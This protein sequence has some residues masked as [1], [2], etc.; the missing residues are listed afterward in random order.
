[1][2]FNCG[3]NYLGKYTLIITE[4]PDAAKRIA[5]ALD[6]NG[7]ANKNVEHG[8]PFYQ[9]YR[10]GEI[11]VVPA[12]G[13]MYTVASKIKNS[14]DYPVFDCTW[15]PRYL[16]EHKSSKIRVWLG[17]I[18]KLAKNAEVFVD[19][20]DFDIEG[21]I[22]GYCLLKYACG[23]KEKAAKRM[24]YSTL[25]TEDLQQS[26]V[27]ILPSLD[28]ALV[29]AGLAR[30]EIDWLY[31]INLSRA[32]TAAA[33]SSS[34]QY[35]T[36]ST[37]RVQ[38]PTLKFL[39]DREKSINSFVPTPYWTIKAKIWINDIAYEFDYEKTLY[40][41]QEANA[42]METCKTKEGQIKKITVGKFAQK[43]PFPFDL[44]S[45]QS[46]AYRLFHYSPMRTLNIA[47]RLYTNALISYPRT[48]S[49]KLP[50][51]IGY[52]QILK[53][54]SQLPI[55]FKVASQLLSKSMLKPHEGIKSDS[56][57]PAI[58]PTGNL[59]EE[60]LGIPERN[61]FDLVVG[62][63]MAVFGEPATRQSTEL[64]LD[65]NG[66]NF[67]FSAIQTL[68]NGW[69]EFYKPYVD[70]KD[71][72]CPST[73]EGQKVEVKRVTLKENFTKA[74]PRYNPSSLLLKM[75]KEEIGTKATRAAIIQTL[76]DRKY[77]NGAGSLAVSQLGLEVI[78]VLEKYCPS[79]ISLE[80]T[81]Q[82][83][84][85]MNQI[86]EGS[87]TKEVVL[88]KAIEIL[89]PVLS[90]L[91]I[92]QSVVGFK[93]SEA[94]NQT[95]MEQRTI[96][97]CPKCS[98][99]KLV[100]VRSKK[101]QKRFVGCANYFKTKCNTTFPLPQVGIIKPLATLC[102]TCGSPMVYVLANNRRWR[103]CLSPNCPTKKTDKKK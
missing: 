87:Q 86:Q 100:I 59:P 2:I 77:L 10:N 41:K 83:E 44:G 67:I 30:H 66:N 89:K 19:A 42:I 43:L 102:K 25:T 56:A 82:L 90:E 57:H 14:R 47:Q 21:S 37:G 84:E 27:N 20:C 85:E 71:S 98:D 39:E 73:T 88:Q 81:K 99:G 5:M 61:V 75:E 31:G 7:N 18:S 70:L 45:L 34:G 93:L 97:A 53:K 62:R 76:S 79:I 33:K 29:N 52:T 91:N 17:V 4:K 64:V 65:I 16:V 15:V 51:Q 32:L 58:Y 46:E 40:N 78:E 94:L 3:Q 22:I 55:Y 8:V 1:V 63:F 68:Q 103:L 72:I 60:S 24:K 101:T 12:I 11:I 35:A 36:I 9:A 6:C 28:F 13:H 49:Q 54:L 26:Y 96:G 38:G 69:L 80:L 95:R 74:P 23:D 48:S 50:P 92:N